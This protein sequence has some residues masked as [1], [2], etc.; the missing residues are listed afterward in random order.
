[1]SRWTGRA[2]TGGAQ[3]RSCSLSDLMCMAA[4][5]FADPE[6]ARGVRPAAGL[7]LRCSGLLRGSARRQLL[8][9]RAVAR[10]AGCCSGRERGVGPATLLLGARAVAPGESGASGRRCCSAR[11]LLPR[12]SARRRASPGPARCQLETARANRGAVGILVYACDMRPSAGSAHMSGRPTLPRGG[13]AER[14]ADVS[15]FIKR[16]RQRQ[17]W[18]LAS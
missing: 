2:D 3:S 17:D 5:P 8:G 12:G 1:M 6:Q 18:R 14:P 13:Q 16:V 9:A 4:A 15:A 7:L 10:R 11:E